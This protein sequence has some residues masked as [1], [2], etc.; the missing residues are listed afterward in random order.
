M[1]RDTVFCQRTDDIYSVE[2]NTVVA[3]NRAEEL[4]NRSALK[5]F[6][7]R[8][9]QNELQAGLVSVLLP[10]LGKRRRVRKG[11]QGQPA[12][13]DQ[14]HDNVTDLQAELAMV[15]SCTPFAHLV[16]QLYEKRIFQ[17]VLRVSVA[18]S[19][20]L[21]AMN[22]AMQAHCTAFSDVVE[23]CLDKEFFAVSDVQE[24]I[25]KDLKQRVG[26]GTL[27]ELRALRRHCSRRCDDLEEEYDD[28]GWP[29]GAEDSKGEQ[30]K[31]MQIC[32]EIISTQRIANS[33]EQEHV[34]VWRGLARILYE[35]DLVVRVGELGS[36]ATREDRT[37]AESKFGGID[38]NVRGRKI[39]IMHQLC[40]QGRTKPIEM[41]AWEVKSESVEAE[42]LQCQLRKNIRINASIMNK[43]SQYMEWDFP[44]P[45]PMV[46]DIV[47][48]RALV[49][50][51]RKVQPEVFGAGAVGENLIELPMN[52]KEI[53]EFLDGGNMSALL[54]IG[55]HNSKFACLLKK[56]YRKALNQEIMAKMTG[57]A[58]VVK[59]GPP[60]I[61]TPMKKQK[62][63]HR[64]NM[65][66]SE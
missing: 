49:Y 43:L 27:K 42:A 31:I 57:N 6:E 61:F 14:D 4:L 58:N 11:F 55:V 50:T 8:V 9:V 36:A 13:S 20:I 64:L 37:L 62:Q 26:S 15:A 52:T 12:M 22:P 41:V 29:M 28:E 45:S 33:S 34:F 17:S 40:L 32:D 18:L 1:M 21:N 19:G 10:S 51:V 53:A 2:Q 38:S 3:I 59:E 65:S 35:E 44:R 48:S 23:Q 16:V 66:I 24:A 5:G 47:G 60:V 56:G 7:H 54:R 30:L 25:Y 63:K 39:D 46:L